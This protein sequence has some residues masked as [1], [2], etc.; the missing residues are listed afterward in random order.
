MSQEEIELQAKIYGLYKFLS[1]PKPDD[2]L[3]QEWELLKEQHEHMVQYS[4]VLNER[5]ELATGKESGNV[6]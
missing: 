4:R 5:I 6:I 3:P 2:V 1:N